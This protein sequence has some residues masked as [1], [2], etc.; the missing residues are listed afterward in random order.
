M[1]IFFTIGR[2]RRVEMQ[3]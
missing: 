2:L 3:K 1:R